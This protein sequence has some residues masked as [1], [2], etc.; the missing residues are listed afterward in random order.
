MQRSVT[1]VLMSEGVKPTEVHHQTR[2]VPDAIIC[3]DD[4]AD[5]C[6]MNEV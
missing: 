5:S 3:K 4:S 2:E 6:G 1:R